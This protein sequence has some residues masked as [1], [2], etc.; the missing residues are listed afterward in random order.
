MKK[1][2]FSSV[3]LQHSKQ[4]EQHNTFKIREQFDETQGSKLLKRYG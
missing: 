3:G 1:F 4:K 2:T